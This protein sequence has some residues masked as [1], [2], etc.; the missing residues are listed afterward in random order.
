MFVL[1]RI[2]DHLL[3][4][5]I[6]IWPYF[7]GKSLSQALGQPV[8]CFF[9]PLLVCNSLLFLIYKDDDKFRSVFLVWTSVIF[10]VLVVS[11]QTGYDIKE[12]LLHFGNFYCN[13]L[14]CWLLCSFLLV[15]NTVS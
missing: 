14:D 12:C 1:F 8:L 9:F 2:L 5:V 6:T 10:A 11:F 15:T 4:L 13:F 7:S 3:F